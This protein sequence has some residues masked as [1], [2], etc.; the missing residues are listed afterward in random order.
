[1]KLMKNITAEEGTTN[2]GREQRE[3]LH[4]ETAVDKFF[5]QGPPAFAV[6]S[7]TSPITE[8]QSVMHYDHP[9]K[10]R[11]FQNNPKIQEEINKQI[12][13][14]LAKGCIEPS[15]SPHSGPMV[16]VK[17]KTGKW[18]VCVDFRQLNSRSV[19]IDFFKKKLKYLGHTVT[20]RGISTDPDKVAAIF[21]LKPPTN[22]PHGVKMVK[23]HR[24]PYRSYRQIG[25]GIA[26]IRFR[27]GIP[28]RKTERGGRRII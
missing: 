23:F 19:K 26:T 22:R 12:D 13:E 2:F 1:M 6:V 25:V 3:S 11:Y 10:Q 15:S 7:G 14:L 28:Q 17:K 8:R 20:E 27:G 16:M 5:H 18:R 21:Q 9:I 24:K 4:P